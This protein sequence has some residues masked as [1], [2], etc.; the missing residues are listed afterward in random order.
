MGPIVALIPKDGA[1][2]EGQLRPIAILPCLQG[3]DGC[4]KEESQG[5]GLELAWRGDQGP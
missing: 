2:S 4:Q 1:E 5:V 3:L